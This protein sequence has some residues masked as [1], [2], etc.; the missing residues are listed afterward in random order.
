MCEFVVINL[1][2]DIAVNF[3]YIWENLFDLD[4]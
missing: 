1:K 4:E 3:L 2:S